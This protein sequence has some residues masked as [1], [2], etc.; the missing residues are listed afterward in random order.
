MDSPMPGKSPQFFRKEQ[1]K[2]DADA[3]AGKL[4]R[5]IQG[6]VR[7]D[8][9]SRALYAADASNYRQVPIG[10][11]LPANVDDV[12]QTVALA[13]S[14][15]A[16]ILSRGA[17]TSLA[18]QCCNVAVVIDMSKYFNQIIEL[19]REKKTA[20][21]RPGL[22][23]DV[24]RK[25][26]TNYGLNFGPDPATHNHCTLGGMLGNDSCGIHSVMA[27]NFGPGS[28]TADN[29]VDMEILTYDGLRLRVGPTTEAE[30]ETI[31]A[32]GGARGHIYARL[33]K[34][35]D[36]YA[37]LIRR[38]YPNI[39][40]RVS[41][42]NLDELLPEKG[43]NVARALVGTESTC[44][45]I[46]EAT[47]QLMDDFPCRTLVVLG[48]ADVYEAAD[49]VTQIMSYKPVGL[50]GLD[51]KLIHFNIKRGIHESSIKMMPE[52]RGWLLVEFGGRTKA[53]ADARA[54]G[55]MESI[56]KQPHPPAIK[57]FEDRQEETLLWEVRE[58][59][60][61]ATAF[62]PGMKDAWPGWEDSA[63]PPIRMGDYLRELRALFH[64]FGYEAALYG[65]F[66]QGCVHCRIDFDLV[67]TEGLLRYRRFVGEAADLVLSFGGSL[68]GEHG[69]G[70]SR[71]E[72]L[73]KMYGA[74]LVQAFREF[75][76]IWDPR[77]K[78]NPGKIV[79]PYPILSNLRLGPDYNPPEMETHF[80]YPHDHHSFARAA[81]R[82]VGIGKCRRQ[83]GGT[84]CPSYMVTR[85]EEHTTRGRA[86]LL[87]EMLNGDLIQKGWRDRHV[88]ESL[89]L[90]LACKGCKADCPV[91]VDMATYKAE[92][93]S[94]YYKGRLRPRPAY[95]M[96]L[97]YWWA[98]MASLAPSIVNY[99]THTVPFDRIAKW[100]GGISPLR[101]MP[102]FARQTFKAWFFKRGLRNLG[103]PQVLLWADTFNNYFFPDTLKAAVEVLERAD[104]QVIVP[105]PSLC[106][107]RPLYDFGML[108]TAERLLKEILE[109]LRPQIQAGIPIVGL[110]PSCVS[111]FRDELV[112]LFP[113]NL[114]AN[115]LCNQT[116]TLAE[117]LRRK[118]G[119]FKIPTLRRPALVH[120]HCHHKAIMGLTCEE[121]LYKSMGLDFQVLES[122]CCGMAGSFGFETDKYDVSV[123]CG[124]RV[125]LPAVRKASSNTLII[126]DGFS[127]REQIMELTPRK[128]L[129]TAEV[130]Q[131]A[132]HEKQERLTEPEPSWE[133]AVHRSQHDPNRSRP[134]VSAAV[135][136]AG[137][138]ACSAALWWRRRKSRKEH[139]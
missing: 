99:F 42:Y 89:D 94:H 54:Y 118:A 13:N 36:K 28:R 14:Y 117:F 125:L 8:E 59:G 74:E 115:R 116:F 123:K 66:G 31:I 53:E 135:V 91:N 35:R 24:L 19:N 20:R 90:C 32:A 18:G 130:L 15:E 9:G 81:L 73:P 72:L 96:G 29:V 48:Y 95:S 93:L 44:V 121:A 47:M 137:V 75:K 45:T 77:S 127:C 43:F 86:H 58:S 133:G 92:F 17:G 76:A 25:E 102:S 100:L 98:R 65:H 63:V 37:S 5:A 122:G 113:S 64:K 41:G 16:P 85:E 57:L 3:L 33:K 38:R 4:Q 124:E 61:G 88:L 106:C 112:N 49:D 7:F 82:C 51:D 139:S 55:M 6:E 2:G 21:V 138:A 34:L 79:D 22:V 101:E 67:T 103:R 111:V 80:K 120:G 52:G 78:M 11:V 83:E 129:H 97:I 71:A 46:L 1:W 110:E 10:V 108:N 84:M 132:L 26:V 27:Q 62:V 114:D 87:W 56:K 40:R 131:M 70:Q 128:P 107:G 105:Q 12:I 68:S 39:P 136:A 23:L 60:L 30:L 134:L 119:D 69:D 109:T 126:A 104:Y 50:E